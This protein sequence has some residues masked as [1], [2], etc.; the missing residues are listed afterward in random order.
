MTWILIWI[1]AIVFLLI[2]NAGAAKRNEEY[3]KG[4]EEFMRKYFGNDDYWMGV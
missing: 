3:D 2:L 4:T 1:A